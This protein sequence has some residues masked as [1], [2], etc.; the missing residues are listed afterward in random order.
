MPRTGEADGEEN[1]PA[2]ETDGTMD[3]HRAETRSDEKYL[4]VRLQV[5]EDMPAGAGVSVPAV[6]DVDVPMLADVGV[7]LVTMGEDPGV[8]ESWPASAE[9]GDI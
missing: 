4:R 3:G 9:T 6:A 5:G 2:I 7:L 1:R 8:R